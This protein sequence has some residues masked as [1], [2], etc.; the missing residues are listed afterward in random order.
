MAPV[1][2]A[3]RR[4]GRD[5]WTS[6]SARDTA[7]P[8]GMTDVARV[9]GVS[10]QTVSRAL[11]GHPNVQDETRAKVLAAVEQLGYR[12]NNAARMLSSGPQPHHRRG[13]PPDQLLL[14][15]RPHP[16]HRTRRAGGR[17]RGQHRHH[18]LTRHLRHRVRA[19]APGRP[20]RGGRDPRRAAH[21]CEPPDRAVDRRGAH[22]HRRRFAHGGDAKWSP[23][24]SR[25]PPAWP[26]GTCSTSATRPS[27]TSRGPSQW[28]DAASR[29]SRLAGSAGSRGPHG[30]AGACGRL[31]AGLRL[32]QRPDPGPYP[33]R[34]GGLR[35]QRR[36]GVRRD[37][38]AARAGP[39]GAGGHLGGRR[40]R[41]RRSP[42]TARPH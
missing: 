34:H 17:I 20:A 39:L 24:T 15:H 28:L 41:H 36:D 6:T 38:G 1:S 22:D 21:P 5:P 12:K 40:R 11:A 25:W 35:G 8:P 9:A 10:A 37:Q 16:R 31:V 2:S 30:P 7:R 29:S 18:R 27:G 42:N 26:P 4:A 14:P 13:H 23:S 33:G 19:A 3:P 32:P